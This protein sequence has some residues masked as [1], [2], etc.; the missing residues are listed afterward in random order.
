MNRKELIRMI[1]NQVDNLWPKISRWKVNFDELRKLA[2]FLEG[3]GYQYWN[4]PGMCRSHYWCYSILMICIGWVPCIL[5]AEIKADLP[6]IVLCYD[7]GGKDFF[8]NIM[9]IEETGSSLWPR[10]IIPM[11]YHHKASPEENNSKHRLWKK[12][13]WGQS[14]LILFI[15]I[16]LNSA[17]LSSQSTILQ[18]SKFWKKMKKN[19]TSAAVFRKFAAVWQH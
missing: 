8:H 6:A 17:L 14:V 3:S 18:H 9:T 7:K 12:N 1:K 15:G 5:K 13:S 19:Q 2:E 11:K 10:T 16:S 4:C